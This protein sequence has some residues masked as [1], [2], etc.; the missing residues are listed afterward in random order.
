MQNDK[1]HQIIAEQ[2]KEHSI[3]RRYHAIVHGKD[4][5]DNGVVNAPI[6]RHPLIE[7]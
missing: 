3:T 1:A 4:K 5:E 2:L 7:K 6:G